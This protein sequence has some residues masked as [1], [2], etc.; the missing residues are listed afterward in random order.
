MSERQELTWSVFVLNSALTLEAAL[1]ALTAI[2]THDHVTARLERH[3]CVH[4][5]T[6]YAFRGGVCSRCWRQVTLQSTTGVLFLSATGWSRRA[7]SRGICGLRR[8]RFR[9]RMRLRSAIRT[10]Q[11]EQKTFIEIDNFKCNKYSWITI[12]AFCQMMLSA[13]TST[14]LTYNLTWYSDEARR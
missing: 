1:H 7:C 2:D 13:T 5:L 3:T 6:H 10:W 9:V 8:W 4:V 14:L 11:V 12:V